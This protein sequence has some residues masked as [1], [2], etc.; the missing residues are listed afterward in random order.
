MNL[1]RTGLRLN[2]KK[3]MFGV[4]SRKLLGYLVSKW[5][6]EA[7]PN[8]IHAIRE[9]EPLNSVCEAQCLTGQH[10]ELSCF[11]AR[12]VEWSLPFF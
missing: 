7:N 5:G 9:M 1:Q 11:I 2:L 10:E 4:R 8:K 12:L 3:C 6:I